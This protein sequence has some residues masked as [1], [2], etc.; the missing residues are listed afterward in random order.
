MNYATE[1]LLVNPAGAAPLTRADVWAG[2]AHKAE[3][4]DEIVPVITRCV[5]LCRIDEHQ[6]DR[7][8]EIAGELI[9]ERVTLEPMRRVV[10]TRLSGPELGVIENVIDDDDESGLTVRF[11]FGL[12]PMGGTASLAER[13][14]S[15][16][17]ATAGYARAIEATL[18]ATRRMLASGGSTTR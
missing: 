8:I 13:V 1:S 4:A 10:F 15:A 12:V 2:L 18:A 5:V 6:F 11:S 17:E 9:I 3:H 16:A 14:F 7:Q